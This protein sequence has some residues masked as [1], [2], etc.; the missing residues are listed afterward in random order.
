MI[1]RGVHRQLDVTAISEVAKRSNEPDYSTFPPNALDTPF[2]RLVSEE[3]SLVFNWGARMKLQRMKWL[4]VGAAGI[5]LVTW[6]AL[7]LQ[8]RRID[9]NALKNAAKGTEWLTYGQSRSEQRYSTMTQI[10]PAQHQPAW[11]RVVV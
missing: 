5:L 3:H 10:T 4:L 9:D 2:E 8:T 6:V 1:L 11:A 7:A